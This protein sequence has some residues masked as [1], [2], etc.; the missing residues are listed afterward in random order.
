[1]YIFFN[2]IIL[3]LT[4]TLSFSC[5]FYCDHTFFRFTFYAENYCM[6][7]DDLQ[8]SK[9]AGPPRE[10]SDPGEKKNETPSKAGPAKKNN[11]YTK[12]VKV[13]PLQAWTGPEVS[14]R[15]KL[16]YFKTIGTLRW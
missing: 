3:K 2:N 6:S 5:T 15:W 4:L 16:L 14:R 8:I 13:I 9:R 7:E 10:G 11:V 1:M 12:L